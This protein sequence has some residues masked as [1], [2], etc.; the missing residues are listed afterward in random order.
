MV[1]EGIIQDSCVL[2]ASGMIDR[3]V[4]YL[5]S[6]KSTLLQSTERSLS[7]SHCVR[8]SDSPTATATGVQI[9]TPLIQPCTKH[10]L[11]VIFLVSYEAMIKKNRIAQQNNESRFPTHVGR[12][13]G[14]M[15]LLKMISRSNPY[16][17]IW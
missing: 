15:L 11:R 8:D 5:L 2:Y 14:Y 1:L 17:L 10:G 13:V 4:K 9:P 3:N 12:T 6:L 16:G 7:L